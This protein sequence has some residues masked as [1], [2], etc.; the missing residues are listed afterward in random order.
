MHRWCL[1]NLTVQGFS[2]NLTVQGVSHKHCLLTFFIF[3]LSFYISKQFLLCVFSQKSILL[4]FRFFHRYENFVSA[5]EGHFS[6]A[7]LESLGMKAT[8]A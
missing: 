3:F 6:M 1:L 8:L 4:S 5:R 7:H 2:L